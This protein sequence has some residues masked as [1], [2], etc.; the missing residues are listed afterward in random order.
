VGDF[1]PQLPGWF[2][3][4]ID[5]LDSVFLFLGNGN[6]VDEL[7]I[8][9]VQRTRFNLCSALSPP[10]VDV[11]MY[12]GLTIVGDPGANYEI[13]YSTDLNSPTNW[14]TLT[15]LTLPVSPYLY[16]DL[17]STNRPKSFYRAVLKQ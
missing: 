6:Y 10:S 2:C 1:H 17:G 9:N 11:H 5:S 3:P 8:S 4:Q 13:Q 14:T 16:F 7:R 15:N 12:A